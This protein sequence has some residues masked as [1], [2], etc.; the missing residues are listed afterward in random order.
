MRHRTQAAK[1]APDT[2]SPRLQ[3]LRPYWALAATHWQEED[4]AAHHIEKQ[5]FEYYL[6][7]MYV[8][9]GRVRARSLMFPGYIFVRVRS[10]WS[11]L[12]NTRGVRKV[13][14]QNSVPI[15]VRHKE[16]LYLR[17]MENAEGVVVLHPPIEIGNRVRIN[18]LG[19]SYCGTSGI[20]S[21]SPR[22]GEYT[23]RLRM[24]GRSVSIEFAE[25]ALVADS[26]I[27]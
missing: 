2:G 24:M 10:G 21:A 7:R 22:E 11:V 4:R 26:F 17:S 20:V 14:V 5:D 27:H 13:Y 18:S 8:T 6:P 12:H 16:L 3:V 1:T 23:V 15:P 9:R 25:A 19:G